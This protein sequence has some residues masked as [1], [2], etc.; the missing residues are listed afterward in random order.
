MPGV[1]MPKQTRHRSTGTG[2]ASM[3][4]SCTDCAEL[5][6]ASRRRVA[7]RRAGQGRQLCGRPDPH[8]RQLRD[9]PLRH[10]HE[11]RPVQHVRGHGADRR[12]RQER[13]DRHHDGRDF[14]QHGGRPAEPAPAEQGLLQRGRVS[15]GPFSG[16]PD[17]LQRRQGQPRSAARSP[18]WDRRSPSCSRP[19]ASTA[20]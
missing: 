6:G 4:R 18:F 15:D 8:L 5:H 14:D 19:A 3:V 12:H 2:T 1:F 16:R 9:G 20:T 7:V 11:P 10:D 13:Q 17:R